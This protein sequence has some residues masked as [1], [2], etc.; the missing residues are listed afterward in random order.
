MF[1]NFLLFFKISVF[2][3]FSTNEFA[4]KNKEIKKY[5]NKNKK[6]SFEN[7]KCYLTTPSIVSLG[8]YKRPNW[9]IWE[10]LIQLYIYCFD[11]NEGEQVE[12][13]VK[14]LVMGWILMNFRF[15]MN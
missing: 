3:L 13:I 11:C 9:P 8:F 14:F 2:F 12:K 5:W 1:N 6:K 4:L 15:I 10:H 7:K